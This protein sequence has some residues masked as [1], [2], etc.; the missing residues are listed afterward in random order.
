MIGAARGMLA[1]A[2]DQNEQRRTWDD[3]SGSQVQARCRG[4]AQASWAALGQWWGQC[5]GQDHR[6]CQPLI[7]GNEAG[8]GGSQETE[9][10]G[11]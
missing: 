11:R 8:R 9:R 5:L 7:R 3:Q 4:S 2:V 6:S 1:W 10:R